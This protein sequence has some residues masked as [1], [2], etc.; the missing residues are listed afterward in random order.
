MEDPTALLKAVPEKVVEEAYSDGVKATL[1]EASKIGVDALKTVRLA[2]FPLQ[3]TSAF[4]DR[5]AGYI[6]RAIR[7][8]PRE[9]RVAPVE[10]LALPIAEKLRFQEEASRITEMYVNLL[11]RAMD[12]DRA[13]EAHPAFLHIVG[14]LAPD[15]ALLIEQMAPL[16]VAAYMRLPNSETPIRKAEREA[17]L[18]A[19]PLSEAQ[20][21]QLSP[22]MVRPEELRQQGLLYT[23]IEHLISLGIAVYDNQP[24]NNGVYPRDAL[25]PFNYW[26]IRLNGLGRLFHSACLSQPGQSS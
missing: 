26:F 1:Q 8:I 10:S 9:R 24:T 7:Q 4:Q 6:D 21:T 14:Q 12:R 15:E 5:L 18:A 11:A 13:H 19:S 23:Y 2:L 16:E 20:R 25:K 17:A 22:I 3:F